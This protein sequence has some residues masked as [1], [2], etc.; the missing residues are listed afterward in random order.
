MPSLLAYA[1]TIVASLAVS[2]AFIEWFSRPI[3][4]PPTLFYLISPGLPYVW[5]SGFIL[6]PL[7]ILLTGL[8]SSRPAGDQFHK[9]KDVA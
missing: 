4:G 5:R 9:T 1:G 7:V 2:A 6:A 3:G 8:L